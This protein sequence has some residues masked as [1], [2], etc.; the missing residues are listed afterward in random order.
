M[1]CIVNSKQVSSV[2]HLKQKTS[3]PENKKAKY[4][5][6]SNRMSIAFTAPSDTIFKQIEKAITPLRNWSDAATHESTSKMLLV[7]AVQCPICFKELKKDSNV[8]HGLFEMHYLMHY[9]N[10][11]HKVTKSINLYNIIFY[12]ND[13]RLGPVNKWE[14]GVPCI[15]LI[16]VI[17]H[18]IKTKYSWG[19]VT[20]GQMMCQVFLLKER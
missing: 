6:G 7:K 17:S 19:Q 16:Y 14:N 8:P 15:K 11:E 2:R 9:T 13:V 12:Q 10:I 4:E 5:Q 3:K 1:E 20:T 18:F